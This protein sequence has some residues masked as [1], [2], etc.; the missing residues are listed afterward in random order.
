MV[1]VRDVQVPKERHVAR[2]PPAAIRQS[3]T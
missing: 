2:E 3:I 1:L